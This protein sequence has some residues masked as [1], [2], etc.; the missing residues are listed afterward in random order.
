MDAQI[1]DKG[2]VTNLADLYVK[3][4]NGGESG[5]YAYVTTSEKYADW[6][7]TE[8]AWIL[9]T[10]T[11]PAPG[12]DDTQTGIEVNILTPGF[13]GKV[14]FLAELYLKFPDGGESGWFAYVTSNNDFADWDTENQ[15]WNLR[16][17]NP[18][19]GCVKYSERQVLQTGEKERARVNISAASEDELAAANEEIDDLNSQIQQL[20]GIVNAYAGKGGG[21]GHQDF[22]ATP[23][24]EA[25]TKCAVGVVW[26]GYTAW[27][28]N[29]SNP[30]ASTFIDTDDHDRTAVEIFN[31]TF[32]IN[33]NNNHKWVLCNTPTTNPPVFQWIDMGID[34]VGQATNS[35]LGIVK[36]STD[37]GKVSVNAD[38]TMTV[39]GY[40][41]DFPIG[42]PFMSFRYDIPDNCRDMAKDNWVSMDGIFAKC[43]D[44]LGGDAMVW[45]K[46]FTTR[47]FKLPK[48]LPGE[49]I[50]QCGTSANGVSFQ[51]GS[52]GGIETHTNTEEEMLPHDHYVVS[53][54]DDGGWATDDKNKPISHFNNNTSGTNEY[55]Y[56]LRAVNGSQVANTGKSSKTGGYIPT[57]QTEKV[58]KPYSIMNPWTAGRILIRVS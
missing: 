47:M 20:T 32:V 57:G 46:N 2:T 41:D 23:S 14:T 36:G 50:I 6:S 37:A 38:G 42:Y 16:N 54:G 12:T 21:V 33:D 55:M 24:Q 25:L 51:F 35:A 49:S 30:A 15:R 31:G 17:N 7:T 48:V 18:S 45:E 56:H 27:I 40:S 34:S 43:Y 11:E 10:Q 9:R 1:N 8:Q 4:P 3:F 13:K 19:N 53:D 39:N 29:A 5:W 58:A 28:W 22:G 44:R 26:P 52:H